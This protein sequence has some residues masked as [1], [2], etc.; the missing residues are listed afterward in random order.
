MT[1]P[2]NDSLLGSYDGG[3]GGGGSSGG[4]GSNGCGELTIKKGPWTP[5]EDAI[6]ME[7][8]EKYGQ[9]NW[10]AIQKNSGLRRCAKSCRLR[11]ANHLRPNLKK[12][13]F[14][15]RTTGR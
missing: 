9:R 3:G 2:D 8:I 10:S 7:Y 4:R 14:T 13:P 5:E 12:G 15:P 6:L 11:W 1:T